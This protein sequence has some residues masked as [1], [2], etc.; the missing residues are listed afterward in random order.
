MTRI[1][2]KEDGK[3]WPREFSLDDNDRTVLIWVRS[4]GWKMAT[5]GEAKSCGTTLAALRAE[6]TEEGERNGTGD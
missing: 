4:I 6:L 2:R 1:V 3:G 5:P